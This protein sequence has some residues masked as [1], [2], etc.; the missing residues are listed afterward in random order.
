MKCFQT[1]SVLR[2]ARLRIIQKMRLFALLIVFG[3]FEN[4]VQGSSGVL[5]NQSDGKELLNLQEPNILQNVLN[6]MTDILDLNIDILKYVHRFNNVNK[7]LSK[8]QSNFSKDA[9]AVVSEICTKVSNIND[10]YFPTEQSIGEWCGFAINLMTSFKKLLTNSNSVKVKLQK[11]FLNELL[12]SQLLQTNGNYNVIFEN[13][14]EA[15][16]KIHEFY[17]IL[18]LDYNTTSDYYEIRV[19]LLKKALNEAA[20][21][22]LNKEVGVNNNDEVFEKKVQ[23]LKKQLTNILR[24]MFFITRRMDRTRFRIRLTKD[25]II[26]TKNDNGVKSQIDRL[27]SI[28][29]E[30]FKSIGQSAD[31]L[32]KR[33][34]II[35]AKLLQDVKAPHGETNAFHS[36]RQS[37]LRGKRIGRHNQQYATTKNGIR[38]YS[39]NQYGHNAAE[40]PQS[41]K[42]QDQSD[43]FDTNETKI[44][45][46]ASGG[47]CAGFSSGFFEADDCYIDS[48]ASYNMSNRDDWM[49]DKYGHE[50]GRVV[51]EISRNGSTQLLPINEVLHVPGLATNLLSV[52]RI[53]SKGFTVIFD[54]KGCQILD[55]DG[56]IFASGQ[57]V[58]KM[59]KL[60]AKEIGSC[61]MAGN[62]AELSMELWH[63][64]M[65]HINDI[66]LM[67]L[68]DNLATVTENQDDV[69][70]S[71]DENQVEA[72]IKSESSANQS[73]PATFNEPKAND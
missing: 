31:K 1:Y 40:C 16:D 20:T 67:K 27:V 25:R 60:N 38:C 44:S 13:I 24:T 11:K 28:H 72:N 30:F 5:E 33:C 56:N 48:G 55:C 29:S 69:G 39:C 3:V 32:L 62:T 71:G 18:R 58:N 10:E 42:R 15:I 7:K 23:D 52:S 63:R 34:D 35:K 17:Q 64:R 6:N 4:V 73:E 22:D 66:H 41:K 57:H 21:K 59:F 37:N 51:M 14:E 45:T 46:Q 61:L 26:E 8:Y 9:N 12:S 68:R 70:S 36:F 53:F 47:F 49:E 65:G 54:M 50:I 19:A 2:E 43:R